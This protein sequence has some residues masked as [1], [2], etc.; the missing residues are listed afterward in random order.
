M[1]SFGFKVMNSATFGFGLSN[2]LSDG[3]VWIVQI[4]KEAGTVAAV[5]Y[6]RRNAMGL[7]VGVIFVLNAIAVSGN[8][9]A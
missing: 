1:S 8:V 3:G 6:A 9:V 5:V 7:V 4:A 2:Y